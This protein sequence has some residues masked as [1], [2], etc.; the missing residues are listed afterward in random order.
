M[1]A[2]STLVLVELLI[3][4]AAIIIVVLI[5]VAIMANPKGPPVA[6]PCRLVTRRFRKDYCSGTCA[7]TQTC[8][9]VATKPWAWGIFGATQAA[10]CAC[11]TPVGAPPPGSVPGIP[12]PAASP[13]GGTA[14]D[15]APVTS[16][17]PH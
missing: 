10:A 6:G 5:V 17:T 16:D 4:V 13:S 12:A 11:G 2:T 14:E 3:V 15:I 1:G 7:G 9:V 8:V